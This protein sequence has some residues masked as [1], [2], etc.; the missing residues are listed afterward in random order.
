MGEQIW[1]NKML[2]LIQRSLHLSGVQKI[3]VPVGSKMVKEHFNNEIGSLLMYTGTQKPDFATPQPIHEFFFKAVAENRER[4]FQRG[5]YSEM[6]VSAKKPAGLNSGAA[7][8]EFQDVESERHKTTQRLYDDFHLQLAEITIALSIEA[9]NE[10]KLE[11][12]R[13][14][15]RQSFD[16]IDFKKDLK[17]L[18]RSEFTLHCHSISRLPKDPA[19]QLQTIQEFVQAGIVSLRRA[20]KLIDFPDLEAEVTMLTAQE[21][22]IEMVLDAIVDDGEYA[23]PEPTDDLALAKEMV[24]QHIQHYRTLGLESERLDML[25]TWNTQV[26]DLTAMAL[27]AAAPMGRPQA[28]PMPPPTSELLPNAPQMARAA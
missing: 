17:G 5:G 13:V 7:Q 6:S 15:G 1:Q 14:P 28:A 10:D 12:V 4:M 9:A 2:D 25:R 3:L 21:S 19:G 8:R 27:P 22:V 23:P 26:D 11:A 16:R 20:V 18:K 24:V